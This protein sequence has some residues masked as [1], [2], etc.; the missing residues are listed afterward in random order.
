MTAVL[1]DRRVGSQEPTLRVLPPHDPA[2]V[3]DLDGRDACAFASR[4]GATPDPWQAAL[5]RDWMLRDH[6]TGR[7]LAGTWGISVPRQNGKNFAVEIIEIYAMVVLGLRILHTAHQV[8]TAQKHFRA[9]KGYFGTK[10]NDPHARY[11][12]LNRLVKE[13]RL[14]NGQEGL[15][16]WDPDTGEDLGS[17]EIVARSKGSARGF[18][19]DVLV[20]DEAQHL[21]DE[22]LEALRP[23][24]SA[25]PSGDP[26]AIYMGTP[27]KRTIMAEDGEGAAFIRIR[28]RALAEGASRSAWVEFGLDVDI[29]LMSDHE[30]EALAGNLDNAYRVN[31][32]LGRRLW[33]QTVVDELGELGARSYCRERLNIWP[34]AEAMSSA[35]M[36]MD[37]WEGAT[38]GRAPTDAPLDSVGLDMDAHG[39]LWVSVAVIGDGTVHVELLPDD[40]LSAGQEVAVEWL[41]RRCG[42]RKPV[43]IPGD[44]G[45]AILEA[46]LRAKKMKVYRLSTSEAV[47]SSAGF[48]K[49]TADGELTHLDDPV[50]AM[51]IKE[52]GRNVQSNGLWRFGRDGD[53]DGA[54]LL[55]A[56]CAR[57]GAVKWSGRRRSGKSRFG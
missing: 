16:L 21:M 41:W 22:H 19:N 13:M 10:V 30:I 48:V 50:L 51:A 3:D 29:D 33:E 47:Q 4:F 12:E 39:R 1:E 14:T 2:T 46:P 8:K 40:I 37:E 54:P 34:S 52:S 57:F 49:A 9:L 7:W 44:S 20:L 11:P 53:L 23:A 32:A 6:E 24:I 27:P 43:V 42:K 35:A 26:V 25:A 28:A 45:A 31:P 17:I 36:D 18:S 38:V 55:A 56:S 5:V 15:W